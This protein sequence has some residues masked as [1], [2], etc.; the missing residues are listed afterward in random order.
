MEFTMKFEDIKIGDKIQI[1]ERLPKIEITRKNGIKYCGT[2]RLPKCYLNRMF[3][4]IETN[5]HYIGIQGLNKKTGKFIKL[6]RFP[7][8][9]TIK[10]YMIIKKIKVNK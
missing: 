4:V 8:K 10:E 6:R 5:K 9:R 2:I 3:E 7:H 1:L